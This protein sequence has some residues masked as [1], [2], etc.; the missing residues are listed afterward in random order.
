MADSRGIRAG[1]LRDVRDHQQLWVLP[2]LLPEGCAAGGAGGDSVVG[3]D[4]ADYVD[5]CFGGAGGGVV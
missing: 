5:E 1:V 2:G 4:V 3:G